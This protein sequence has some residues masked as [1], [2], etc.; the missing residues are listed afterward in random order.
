MQSLFVI[1]MQDVFGLALLG[2]GL[3]AMAVFS[4]AEYIRRKFKKDKS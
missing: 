1:T 4:I 2:V 3:S